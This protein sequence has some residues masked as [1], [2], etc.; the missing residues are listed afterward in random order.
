MLCGFYLF[1]KL[2]RASLAEWPVVIGSDVLPL[3][4]F[5]STLHR[6]ALGLSL[7]NLHLPSALAFI[8]F[9]VSVSCTGGAIFLFRF[10]FLVKDDVLLHL[11]LGSRVDVLSTAAALLRIVALVVGTG[12]SVASLPATTAATTAA[13]T[14]ATTSCL[15]LDLDL[16]SRCLFLDGLFSFQAS[17]K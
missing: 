1:F 9:S 13:S 4:D 3:Q 8:E 6:I 16:H 10:L 7:K 11:D 14:A 12:A 17:E 2:S 15:G 5:W